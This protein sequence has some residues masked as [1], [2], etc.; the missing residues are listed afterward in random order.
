MIELAD[1]EYRY[2]KRKHFALAGITFTVRPG[3]IFTLLGPNGAGKTTII[4]ILSGLILPHRGTVTVRGFDMRL[5]ENHARESIGLV[6][7][8][9]RTFYFRLSGKQNLEFFGGLYGVRRSVLKSRID[10][11]LELVG[12]TKDTNLQFMRYSTGMRKRLNLARSLLHDP[13]ILLLDEPNSGVDPESAFNIRAAILEKRRQGKTILLTTHNMTEAEK[14]CDRIGFL[15]EGKLIKVGDVEEY[16]GLIKKRTFEVRF[17]PD[18]LV[19]VPGVEAMVSAVK[20]V[21]PSGRVTFRDND[22]SVNFNG[23]YDLNGVLRAIC[24]SGR[25]VESANTSTATLEDV[26]LALTR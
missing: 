7:G 17:A 8:D 12:L 25:K 5:Q 6:L 11:A 14:M 13:D 22:L 21:V 19:D 10:A 20:E 1:I 26:F 23:T 15:R 9:E 18:Q 24:R 4:R 16:K 2:P 3:E